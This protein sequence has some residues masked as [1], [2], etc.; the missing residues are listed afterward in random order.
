MRAR[1]LATVI[2]SGAA[3]VTKENLEAPEIQAMRSQYGQ[4]FR[5]HSGRLTRLIVRPSL[6][7]S[8]IRYVELR[9]RG[10]FGK[11]LYNAVPVAMSC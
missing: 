3:V 11:T 2:D 8:R 6:K 9:V 1:F 4:R 5:P 10:L 7:P